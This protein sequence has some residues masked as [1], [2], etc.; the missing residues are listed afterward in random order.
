MQLNPLVSVIIPFYNSEKFIKDAIDSVIAQTYT[1]WELLLIDDGSTDSSTEIALEYV[2]QYHDKFYYLEH[3]DHKNKGTCASRNLA[4]RNSKGK[5]IALLDSDDVW[6]PEKLEQQT[7][8][9]RKNKD[10]DVV[11]GLSEYWH[12]WNSNSK[13]LTKDHI[14][15]LGLKSDIVYKPPSLLNLIFPLGKANAPCPSVLIMSKRILEEIGGFEEA[16]TG[17][18]QYYEDQA[19]LSKL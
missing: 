17:I 18:Y 15:E 13:E 4:I 2:D 12:S 8:I 5:Y 3:K 16:F 11:F 7:N 6:F 19:F 1:N 14:P 9:I 10:I